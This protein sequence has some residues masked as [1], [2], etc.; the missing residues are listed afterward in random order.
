VATRSGG[1]PG[2][3]LGR[4]DLGGQKDHLHVDD[5]S[6]T[7]EASEANTVFAPTA[8][9]ATTAPRESNQRLV[10]PVGITG[11]VMTN[12]SLY[13]PTQMGEPISVDIVVAK[14]TDAKSSMKTGW[15]FGPSIPRTATRVRSA[16]R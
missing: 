1:E 13:L 6:A 3:G 10:R 15:S 9:A 8:A 16:A 4:V 7:A 2:V 11:N 5:R 12:C 14:V